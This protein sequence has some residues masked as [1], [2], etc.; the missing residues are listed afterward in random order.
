MKFTIK[1]PFRYNLG[2]NCDNDGN[3]ADHD[4]LMRM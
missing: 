3:Y 4:R 1:Y 2:T